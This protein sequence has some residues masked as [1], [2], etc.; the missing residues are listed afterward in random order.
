MV[1]FKHLFGPVNSRRLGLSLGVDLIPR[2][3]CPYDCSYC[4]VGPTTRQT[5]ARREYE[6]EAVIRE[7][8]E[9][10][11]REAQTPDFITLA[12]SGEPTLNRGTGRIIRAVKDMTSIPVAVLT[13]GA[14]LH[15]PEVRQELAAADVILPTLVSGREETWRAVNRPLPGMSL[16]QIIA[17]L[18]ALVREYRGQV[19]LEVMILKGLN[20][21]AEE[22]EALDQV[23]KRL[24]PARV[25]LNT[26]VRP[27]AY[28]GA[29]PLDREEM[30]AVA[31]FLGEGAEVIASCSR[32]ANAGSNISEARFLEM[33]SRRP[34][35]AADLAQALG[36]PLDQVQ[37]KLERLEAAGRIFYNRYQEQGFYRQ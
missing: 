11:A 9:Y 21:T 1:V 5:Q 33:L 26:A 36:L 13:N 14:L 10:L 28:P 25:Q 17:G 20:D 3:T 7:L 15:L 2:K 24:A 16:A 19:W 8:R 32:A 29:Q 30:A 6:T 12:G 31:A 35:T 18:E 23:I 27:G 4:E 37:E 34:M 22:L